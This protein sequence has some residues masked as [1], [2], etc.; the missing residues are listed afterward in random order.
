M[1]REL[2]RDDKGSAW[3]NSII[4]IWVFICVLLMI[5]KI[6]PIFTTYVNLQNFTNNVKRDIEIYGE[7]GYEVNN[8]I[9]LYKSTIIEPDNW[10]VEG[11]MIYGTSKLQ[12]N[13]KFKVFAEKEIEITI[14]DFVRFKINVKVHPAIG[15]SDIYWKLE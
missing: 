3:I 6:L 13:T 7:V 15:T 9:N 8:N 11:D 4:M 5:T 1:I 10:Y 2:L 14:S 12:L